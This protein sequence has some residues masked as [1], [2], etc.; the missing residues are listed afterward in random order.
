MNE[1]NNT[2]KKSILYI[3]DQSEILIDALKLFED[4]YHYNLF[5]EKSIQDGLDIL[6]EYYGVIDAIILDLMFPG[7]KLQGE[8]GLLMIKKKYPFIPVFIL[9][10]TNNPDEEEKAKE[11]L[12][13]GA[14][15]YYHKASFDIKT[16][17]LQID[18]A[19]KDNQRIKQLC[20][21]KNY[22]NIVT[23]T[24]HLEIMS[25]FDSEFT[26][27][28]AYELVS[29]IKTS[30]LNVYTRW[31]SEVLQTLSVG[32]E[33]LSITQLFHRDEEV[34]GVKIYLL[35]TLRENTKIK[36]TNSFEAVFF[37]F[38]LFFNT[39][40]DLQPVQFTPI[41]NSLKLIKIA[42]LE[43]DNFNKLLYL[44]KRT[45][46]KIKKYHEV[47]GFGK[48]LTV[49]QNSVEIPLHFI[50]KSGQLDLLFHQ[51][52][53]LNSALLVTHIKKIKLTI[54]EI[55]TLNIIKSQLKEPENESYF[56]TVNN[57]LSNQEQLFQIET[58]FYTEAKNATAVLNRVSELF[59]E[60]KASFKQ[61]NKKFYSD[62]AINEPLKRFPYL[63]TV[64]T[65]VNLFIIPKLKEEALNG[66]SLVR[67]TEVSLPYQS[68]NKLGICIGEKGN[69]KVHLD[70]NQFKKHTYIIGKTGTGKTSVLYAMLMDCISN[71]KGIA[72][73]DP[74]GDVFDTVLKNIPDNRK[75]DVIIFDPTDNANNFGFNILTFNKKFPEQ[76]S[77]IVD[78]LMKL[79]SEMY[80]M[81][82]VAGPM[83][84]VYFKNAAYLVMETV[85]NATLD[86]IGKV[87]ADN[88]FMNSC[89]EK[90]KNSRILDFFKM[91]K[92]TT[93]EQAFEN[94]GPYI[95]SK[96][97]RFTDNY[98][99]NRVICDSSKSFDFRKMIDEGKIFL[100]K[101]NKGR[102][103]YEA[104]NFIGRLLFSRIIMAAYTRSDIAE[105][106]RKD[107]TL[108]VDEFQNFTSSDIVSAL[109]EARKYHLQLV[110]ANQ[111]FAQ[112]NDNV[113]KNILS[114]VGS[115]I[116]AA[117]SPFDADLIVP[118][119]EPEFKRQDIIQ[120]DNFKF[121]VK[122]FYD[123]KRVS[124]FVFNSI[125][126]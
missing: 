95:T 116:S 96:L 91:A 82:I 111:T 126:Y 76:Q 123:N 112:L 28:F 17:L 99:L 107:Y 77:F 78:E 52:E 72:L 60:N 16:F 27:V 110:L 33:N 44:F 46:K 24:P 55:K 58:I 36:I 62:Y 50:S 56:A 57:L 119:L 92:R 81:K 15:N 32:F 13:N 40:L 6:D 101:L 29:V 19:I 83:F 80:D 84:E 104:V 12:S 74:H 10:G 38:S 51:M 5:S 121:I 2:A 79:L 125:P 90:C 75:K 98:F 64:E 113:T 117:V 71:G 34:P 69:K 102:L 43:S 115:I 30:D 23:E 120:L 67:A 86:D 18:Q 8:D 4:D 89:L 37:N 21:L 63:Y 93:G 87:F 53:G 54:E 106:E 26:G 103:G 94:F 118:F 14:V 3:D 47:S 88:V 1:L 122:T 85:P 124:P 9:T 41:L 68:E 65:A 31:C 66:Y 73:I 49:N 59:Y 42:T 105:N 7:D 35:F 48:K 109:S 114:N 45:S 20:R 70:Y 22:Q 11:C 61:V 100:V 39:T 108:F 25:D 97:T